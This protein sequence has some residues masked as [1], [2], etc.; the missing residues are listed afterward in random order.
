MNHVVRF[1][2]GVLPI[3]HLAPAGVRILGALE[4]TARRLGHDLTVTCV[5]KEHPPSDPHSLGAALDIRTHDLP[6]DVKRTMLKELMLELSDAASQMDAP[7]LVSGGWATMHFWGWI[8][9]PGEPN[10]HIHTQLRKG[11]SYP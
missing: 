8:E 10:E 9:H 5:D 4:V 11:V 1:K 6:D 2:D 3:G 7:M